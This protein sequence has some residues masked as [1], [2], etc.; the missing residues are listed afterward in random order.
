MLEPAGDARLIEEAPRGGRVRGVLRQEDL[1]G[2]FAAEVEIAGAEDDPHAAAT[3]LA[4]KLVPR[5]RD[6]L[7]GITV[8]LSTGA[9]RSR[10]V[11]GVGSV[12]PGR[13]GHATTLGWDEFEQDT[14]SGPRVPTRGWIRRRFSVSRAYHSCEEPVLVWV[15]PP[16][17]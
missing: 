16:P 1:D 9:Q 14:R 4:E 15:G 5:R 8:S 11:V 6:D 10:H 12:G 3:D 13:L 2:D 17:R 7:G